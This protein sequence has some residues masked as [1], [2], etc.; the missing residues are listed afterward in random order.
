[1]FKREQNPLDHEIDSPQISDPQS[2]N[3]FVSN[4]Y[5]LK[6]YE[7]YESIIG[8]TGIQTTNLVSVPFRN[9]SLGVATHYRLW[10]Y[11]IFF[12]DID[13]EKIVITPELNTRLT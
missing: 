8:N 13:N 9:N 1:M 3:D 2:F 7:S 4:P 10:K 12:Q 11:P 5:S 6:L